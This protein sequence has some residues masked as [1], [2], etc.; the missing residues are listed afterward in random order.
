M[1]IR[2]RSRTVIF[3]ENGVQP[4]TEDMR[5]RVTDA[6]V[7]IE[8]VDVAFR[9]NNDHHLERLKAEIRNVQWDNTRVYFDVELF[10]S[11]E[12]GNVGKGEVT[13]QILA[14]VDY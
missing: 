1:G 13:C 10:M 14:E 11:D 6:A 7:V 2:M 9:D 8:G 3:S 4:I 5:Y 12:S